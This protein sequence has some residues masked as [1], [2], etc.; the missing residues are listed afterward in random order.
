MQDDYEKL[1]E[2]LAL[3]EWPGVYLFKFIAP[4]DTDIVARLTVLF[5]NA[6][7]LKYTPSK[8]GKYV[9]VSGKEMMLDVESIIEKYRTVGLIKG[10][11]AL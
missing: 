4:N 11:I 5:D 8:N 10:V 2:Q 7:D 9:S 3:Q 6:T 1:K